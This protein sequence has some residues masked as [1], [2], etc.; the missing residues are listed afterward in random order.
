MSS[1]GL[2]HDRTQKRK[3]IIYTEDRL[4]LPGNTT[5]KPYRVE[6]GMSKLSEAR[7]ASSCTK[8]NHLSDTE[9]I[10]GWLSR[11]AVRLW[12]PDIQNWIRR[13]KVCLSPDRNVDANDILK[14]PQTALLIYRCYKSKD[15]EYMLWKAT[16]Y[17]HTT[18]Y[19]NGRLTVNQRSLYPPSMKT[20]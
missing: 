2:H 4:S 3:V 1:N 12:L 13:V 11:D 19:D 16:C 7:V 18:T 5:A 14:G 6:Y 15:H 20:A 17:H 10:S 8:Q 9:K